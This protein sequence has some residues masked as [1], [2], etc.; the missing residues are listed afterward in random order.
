M[1]SEIDARRK[2]NN[3]YALYEEVRANFERAKAE[4]DALM[5][6]SARYTHEQMAASTTWVVSHNLN[7]KPQVTVVDSAG[8]EVIGDV[9][10]NDDNTVTLSFSAPFSGKAYLA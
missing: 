4:L 9:A 7:R 6:A 1:A 10:Y 5:L 8:T 3:G 2:P